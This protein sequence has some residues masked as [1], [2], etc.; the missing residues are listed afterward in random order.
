[1]NDD[2]DVARTLMDRIEGNLW[3]YNL[4]RIVAL[5]VT[6]DYRLPHGPVP[7]ECYPVLAE[8]WVLASHIDAA[9]ADPS[10]VDGYLYDWHETP[11]EP[12]GPWYVGMVNRGV[13][14][15]LPG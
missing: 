2:T 10:L 13:I 12:S 14:Q 1:M 3:Q 4:V 11:A 6:D 5:D 7:M 8:K 9:L 15:D